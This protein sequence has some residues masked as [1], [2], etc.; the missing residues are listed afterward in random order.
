MLPTRFL[1]PLALALALAGG[2]SP[3]LAQTGMI[4][5]ANP[6]ADQLAQE[7]RILAVSPQNVPALLRAGELSARLGD[8]SA[9]F[10]FFARAQAVDPAN[11]RILAG[12]AIALV[13]LGRPGEAL[14]L[15]QTAESRGVQ[16]REY[17]AER[18]FAYDLLG[19][20]QLA[21]RD[22]QL[23]L[24]TS[25]DDE[26]LRRYALSLGIGGNADAAMRQLD[27]LLRRQDR[28]A[29]RTRAFILAMNG[30]IAG[31][32]RIA[33]S[34]MPGNMGTALTPFFRRL[35]AMTPADRAFA[36]H[37]GELSS[38]PARIADARMAP[39]LAPY[40]PR[41]SVQ[42]AHAQPN[43]RGSA[44]GRR[45]RQA[46]PAT[47]PRQPVVR[48]AAVTPTPAPAPARAEPAPVRATVQPSPSRAPAAAATA[49]PGRGGPI[50][51][52]SA[53]ERSI[54]PAPAQLPPA[55]PRDEREAATAIA[56]APARTAETRAP[57]A[58]A[59]TPE[60]GSVMAAAAL[61][62]PA[63]AGEE[64]VVLASIIANLTIPAEEL[65]IVT[66]TPVEILPA[67]PAPRVAAADPA[68]APVKAAPRPKPEPKPAVAKEEKKAAAKPEPKPA[69]KKPEPK[70]KPDPSRIWVQVASGANEGALPKAWSAAVAKAPAAF[71]GKS[72]WSTA[73]G[74]TN[75]VLAGPFKNSAEAQAFVNT[76]AKSGVSAFVVS[77]EAGQKVTKLGAK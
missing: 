52:G 64:D 38:T 32:E 23:A 26:T 63:R 34:M 12:R 65:Q 55:A 33:S 29:W 14:H 68:P 56:A 1:R 58:T 13:R 40:T 70:A 21:Q 66:A 20:P 45:S 18:G 37:F 76:L 50:I 25:R 17:A 72:G 4:P 75:R 69:A 3:A 16:M 67:A 60:Q 49:S 31:A 36:A 22:Y 19:Q 8:S 51:T 24:Q 61:P 39:A 71:K 28:A 15:F 47:A 57:S 27:P 42:V 74:A 5:Q 10:A 53:A 46:T 41:Q 44:G 2:G 48:S 30:D 43:T 62:G 6:D 73:A 7:I 9:A 35:A 59:T 77:S 11:P 54:E